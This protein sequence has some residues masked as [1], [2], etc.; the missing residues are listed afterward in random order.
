M[1]ANRE[2]PIFLSND[3]ESNI[4]ELIGPAKATFIGIHYEAGKRNFTFNPNRDISPDLVDR[5]L[6]DSEYHEIDRE[7]FILKCTIIGNFILGYV[8][9]EAQ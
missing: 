9:V 3:D 1:A 7:A 6:H 2:F 8:Q 5:Y 4:V